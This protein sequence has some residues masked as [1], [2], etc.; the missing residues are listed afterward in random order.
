MKTITDIFKVI[1]Q[2]ILTYIAIFALLFLLDKPKEYV[3]MVVPVT[4]FIYCV[5]NFSEVKRFLSKK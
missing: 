3:L 1:S 5:W 2:L 4:L